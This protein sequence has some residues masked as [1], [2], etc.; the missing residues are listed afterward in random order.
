MMSIWEE[1]RTSGLRHQG[2][3]VVGVGAP[4]GAQLTRCSGANMLL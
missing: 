4:E 2:R 1:M 3:Q